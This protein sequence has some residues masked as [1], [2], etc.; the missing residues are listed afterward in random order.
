MTKSKI[1]MF[2][3]F[4]TLM[5]LSANPL[6]SAKK[7]TVPAEFSKLLN[8]KKYKKAATFCTTQKGSVM[9]ECYRQLAEKR[10]GTIRDTIK[11]KK[12]KGIEAVCKK[13]KGHLKYQLYRIIV[14][15]CLEN[16][17]FAKALNYCR[18]YTYN[19][20]Y[21]QLA[22]Y[23]LEKKKFA[24]AAQWFEKGAP[25]A[26]KGKGLGIL[27]DHYRT[28]GDEATAKKFYKKAKTAYEFVFKSLLI[29]WNYDYTADWVRCSRQLKF[30]AKSSEDIAQKK[31]MDNILK[32][33]AAYCNK[34]K[35]NVFYYFCNEKI[36]ESVANYQ[37]SSMSITAGGYREMS[38]AKAK[39][40]QYLYEYQLIQDEK[41]IKETRKLL[42]ENNKTAIGKKS[43]HKA[44]AVRNEK[45]VFGPL[46]LMMKEAQEHYIYRL[47][48]EETINNE[49]V[50]VIDVIPHLRF[51]RYRLFGKVWLR[52]SDCA[53]LKIQ[54]N[55][56]Y[57][58]SFDLVR[59]RA[60]NQKAFPAIT[61]FTE[62]SVE[63]NGI[64]FPGKHYIQEAYMKA[65]YEEPTAAT[66]NPI[67]GK[68]IVRSTVTV[69][70]LK[71]RF[72]IVGTEVVNEEEM[73]TL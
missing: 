67:K 20:G 39:D 29:N 43:Q 42:S 61:T 34:L 48:S 16:D 32:K 30:L 71:Y 50:L 37:S 40:F 2:I 13:Q 11:L 56:K 72:F 41:G 57:I 51:H 3:T 35:S 44:Q 52:A 73:G 17:D 33:A 63:K 65:L 49:K 45:M 66:P 19:G 21:N 25:S 70:Y 53:I 24:E 31:K 15:A 59:T 14:D 62:Y 55:H 68:K 22:S 69:E 38:P 36:I 27:A 4:I 6:L 58:R 18:T 46:M 23:C 10:F 60:A 28:S 5:M 26:F 47:L 12:Y 1:I 54:W 7:L 8:N 9:D 64:R